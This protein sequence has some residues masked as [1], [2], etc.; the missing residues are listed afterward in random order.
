LPRC[1]LLDHFS[2]APSTASV[3]PLRDIRPTTTRRGPAALKIVEPEGKPIDRTIGC[4]GRAARVGRPFALLVGN[5]SCRSSIHESGDARIG[6]KTD[7]MGEAKRKR[8]AFC[9]CGSGQ[10]YIT[11]RTA[12][13]TAT[14]L[15]ASRGTF[16]E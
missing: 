4:T 13:A 15:R 11:G 14:R 10:M 7:D 16:A 1:W 3:C 2:I 5:C 8:D 12:L 9:Q 6:K